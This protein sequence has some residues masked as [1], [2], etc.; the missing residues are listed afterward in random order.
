MKSPYHE[1]PRSDGGISL[2][3]KPILARFPLSRVGWKP[4]LLS[5]SQSRAPGVDVYFVGGGGGLGAGKEAEHNCALT[6]SA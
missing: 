3:H 4:V 6:K 5:V 2:S 1:V